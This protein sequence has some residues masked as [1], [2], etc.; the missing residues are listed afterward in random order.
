M[1]QKDGELSVCTCHIKLKYIKLV[2]SFRFEAQKYCHIWAIQVCRYEGYGFQAVYSRVGYINQRVWIQNR[3]SFSWK[4][5][6]WLK[7]LVKTKETGIATQKYIKK[8]KSVLFWLDSA[9][10]RSSFWVSGNQLLHD[11]G[12]LGSLIQYRVAKFN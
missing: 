9:S 10:N 3:V 1:M 8:I 11:R 12:D 7:I 6:N 5:T 2:S 4:L